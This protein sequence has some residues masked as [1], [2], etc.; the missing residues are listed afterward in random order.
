MLDFVMAIFEAYNASG[1]SAPLSVGPPAGLVG[2]LIQFVACGAAR[3]RAKRIV[4]SG[5]NDAT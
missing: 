2:V 5:K 4:S 1:R 3:N